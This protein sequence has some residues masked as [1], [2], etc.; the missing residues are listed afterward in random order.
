MSK[1]IKSIL[2]LL[3]VLQCSHGLQALDGAPLPAVQGQSGIHP[4]GRSYLRKSRYI[5]HNFGM[6]LTGN[7]AMSSRDR[8]NCSKFIKMIKSPFYLFLFTCFSGLNANATSMHYIDGFK[9]DSSGCGDL[10]RRLMNKI[11]LT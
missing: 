11:K 10:K 8:L 2:F 4:D 5:Q 3:P 9:I 1:L 6:Q 7:L